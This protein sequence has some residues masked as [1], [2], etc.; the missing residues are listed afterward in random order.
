MDDADSGFQDKG[1]LVLT[2][3]LLAD[4]LGLLRGMIAMN[5]LRGI[6]IG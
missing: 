2:R 6:G 4:K 3:Q 5:N 1:S